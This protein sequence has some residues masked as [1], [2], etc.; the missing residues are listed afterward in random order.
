MNLVLG[1]KEG[2][3]KATFVSHCVLRMLFLCIFLYTLGVSELFHSYT[4]RY[5]NLL[6][7]C[8]CP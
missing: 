7:P 3:T 4:F 8:L 1:G 6:C 5:D 2:R